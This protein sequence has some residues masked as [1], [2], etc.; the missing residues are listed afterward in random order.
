[1]VALAYI[2]EVWLSHSTECSGDTQS[3]QVTQQKHIILHP[4]SKGTTRVC[5]TK[6]EPSPQREITIF[7]P[8]CKFVKSFS[9]SRLK[10]KHQ[11]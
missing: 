3:Q 11:D 4:L 7:F 10:P 6:L 1:M 2:H 5:F 9:F 8:Y